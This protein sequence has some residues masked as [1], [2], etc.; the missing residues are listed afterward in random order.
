MKRR[1]LS[2]SGPH[3]SHECQVRVRF[4]ECDPLGIV[5]HGNFIRYF[6]DGREGFGREHGISYLSQK[7][8]G[9]ASPIVKTTT[10]H[11][12]PLRYGD[13]ATVRTYFV[14]TPAAKMVFRFE[15]YDSEQKLACTGETIQ[16]FVDDD[17]ELSLTLPDFFREW[18]ERMGLIDG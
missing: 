8:N 10:E 9:Y 1:S 3:L 11:Q 13:V 16:V 12:R 2:E 4:E 7:E 15:I 17:L 14:N 5:W 18:K 6:E